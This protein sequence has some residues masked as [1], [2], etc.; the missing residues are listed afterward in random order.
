MTKNFLVRDGMI[1]RMVLLMAVDPWLPPRKRMTGFF[2]EVLERVVDW[3]E[4]MADLSKLPVTTD[5]L[6]RNLGILFWLGAK[7][8]AICLQKRLFSKVERLTVSVCS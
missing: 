5:L 4:K 7:E 1:D 6:E 8:R 2:G 3:V